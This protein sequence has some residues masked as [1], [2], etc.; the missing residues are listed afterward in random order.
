ME[1]EGKH[2]VRIEALGRF[3]REMDALMHPVTRDKLMESTSRLLVGMLELSPEQSA[4]MTNVL[5]KNNEIPTEHELEEFS[6]SL[7]ELLKLG[8]FS[9]LPD[10][11]IILFGKKEFDKW[12]GPFIR[13]VLQ[14]HIPESASLEHINECPERFCSA[15]IIK[16]MFNDQLM[17]GRV[18]VEKNV[19]YLAFPKET[20][21]ARV[22]IMRVLQEVGLYTE[23]EANDLMDD[24]RWW[25]ESID[26]GAVNFDRRVFEG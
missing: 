4:T 18:V 22:A 9:Q 20:V 17:D 5:A 3:E 2:A 14:G 24:Y 23:T 1:S 16:L 21:H 11:Y 10:E 7:P 26:D 19:E 12:I 6:D 8:L 13:S 25:L 15:K